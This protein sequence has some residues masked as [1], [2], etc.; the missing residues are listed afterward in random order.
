MHLTKGKG[1][2]SDEADALKVYL[3]R[4]GESRDGCNPGMTKITV[5]FSPQKSDSESWG[6]AFVWDPCAESSTD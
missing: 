5:F 2:S 4:F 1:L 6:S 3:E